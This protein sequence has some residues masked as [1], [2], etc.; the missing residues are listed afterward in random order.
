VAVM[1]TLLE[2]NATQLVGAV[3]VRLTVSCGLTVTVAVAVLEHPP[4]LLAVT[5]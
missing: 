4:P 1:V 2:D 3:A 5:T